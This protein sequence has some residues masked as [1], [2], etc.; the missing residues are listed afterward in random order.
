MTAD[1]AEVDTAAAKEDEPS[2]SKPWHTRLVD[3]IGPV[4]IL[5]GLCTYTMLTLLAHTFYDSTAAL[6]ALRQQV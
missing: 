4:W 3:A 5:T 2:G 6:A 1:A